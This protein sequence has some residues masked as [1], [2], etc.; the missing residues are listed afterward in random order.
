MDI[1]LSPEQLDL[2]AAV[3][4]FLDEHYSPERI[5]QMEQDEEYPEDFYSECARRGWTGIPVPKEYGG[6]DGSVLDLCVLVEEVGKTSISLAT[7]Y[8]T[9]TIFGSHALHICGSKEQAKR[10]LPRI[11]S[12]ENRFALAMS[13]PDAGSD[14]AGM[15]TRA[16]RVDGGWRIDGV[17]GPISG[18]ER[19]DVIITAARTS[20]VAGGSRHK[21]ISLFLVENGPSGPRFERTRYAAMRALMVNKV[22]YEG[23]VVPDSAMLGPVDEGWMN[24]ARLMDPERLANA[25]QA[26]GVA[27]AA[28]DDGV[29]YAINRQQYGQPISRY[30]AV[31][32]PLAE[33]EAEVAAARL[34]VYAAAHKRDVEGPCPKE[35]SMAKMLANNVALRA[36]NAALQC[37]GASGYERDS[38]FMRRVLEVRGCELGGGTSQIQR[39]IIARFM[40]M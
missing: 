1:Y 33:A 17:K 28:I 9:G 24:L 18:A 34:L 7:L 25:A 23:V 39:N 19:A 21:G 38:H 29:A 40:G 8:I 6:S 26:I 36:T 12:G 13:E 32:H 20:T 11:V 3:R 31:S 37:A 10:F 14:F 15:E 27:Q 35:A 4:A 16:E 22:H 2:R 30:Q 5:L